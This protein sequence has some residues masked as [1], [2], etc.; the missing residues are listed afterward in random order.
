MFV[1]RVM[2]KVEAGTGGS[3]QVS[4]RREKYVP[5]GGPDGGDGGRGGS[6]AAPEQDEHADGVPKRGHGEHGLIIAPFG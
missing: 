1:D 3:G 4:F 2:V 6:Q 5:M